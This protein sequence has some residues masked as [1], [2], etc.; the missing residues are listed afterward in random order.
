MIT[1]QKK[2]QKIM[3]KFIVTGGNGYMSDVREEW[4]T[5]YV[6]FSYDIP[7]DLSD[8]D[9]SVNHVQ[10]TLG[11]AHAHLGSKIRVNGRELNPGFLGSFCTINF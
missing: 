5:R 9:Q 2:L 8:G 3:R 6:V 4:I 11:A 1:H 10:H 7:E